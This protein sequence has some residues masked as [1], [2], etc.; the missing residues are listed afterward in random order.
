MTVA[1]GTSI[2]NNIQRTIS[3]PNVCSKYL[4]FFASFK[5]EASLCEFHILLLTEACASRSFFTLCISGS[6]N[7][8]LQ[9]RS[10]PIKIPK[11]VQFLSI[12][13]D[14]AAK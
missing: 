9:V 2:E 3:C 8:V 12:R 10:Q 7:I 11:L 1:A 5:R 13:F 6:M 14:G 4:G